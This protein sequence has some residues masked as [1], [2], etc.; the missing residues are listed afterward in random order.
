MKWS[1]ALT[2][3]SQC[4]LGALILD[5][6][7]QVR[8]INARGDELLHGDG[9]L[10]GAPLPAC[11][12]P[13]LQPVEERVYG[14][15][16]FGEY[17]AHCPTPTLEDLPEGYRFLVFQKADYEACHDMLLSALNQIKE[18]VIICD[19]DSRI[20]FLNDAAV[21]MDGLTN[22]GVVGE[23]LPNVYKSQDDKGLLVPWVIEHKQPLRDVRQ[24][25]TTCRGRA[26]DIMASCYPIVQNGQVLGGCSVMEDWSTVDELHKKIIDL[27]EKLLHVTKEG[28]KKAHKNVLKAKYHFEDIIFAS[29]A[30]AA[31][32]QRCRH[33]AKS[34]SSILIYGETGTGKELVAQSIHNASS[35]ADG[36][37][38][39]INC[40]AIPEN[41]LEGILFGMEK[42]AYTGA[43]QRPGLFEQA[44]GGTLLLDEINSMNINLQ[45]K[46]LRVLQEGTV[47]RVGGMTEHPVDVRVLSNMNITPQQ[48]LE[49]HKLRRDLFY[50]LGVVDL[51]VPPLRE[52][53]E[54]VPLLAKHF[55]MLYNQKLNKNVRNVD[56]QVLELFQSYNWPG[57][58]REL[59]HAIEFA[60]N[61]LPDDR[62][63]ITLDYIPENIV[64]VQQEEKDAFY[65]VQP[66]L[67]APYDKP[68][69]DKYAKKRTLREVERAAV[70]QALRHHQGNI[71]A[72]ARQLGMSRQNL[73]YRIKRDGIDLNE[74][75]S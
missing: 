50:R 29:D 36:P 38:L 57:N 14:N 70:C 26:V 67:I 2:A 61:V 64:Q 21:R 47:R 3:L 18:S 49:E 24:H 13:L 15:P 10:E 1:E 75:L 68:K 28:G 60:M 34:S 27:Q 7:G 43:E 39:A 12:V 8:K 4:G 19:Q 52:R 17:I 63:M 54:D 55:I 53:M 56:A 23:K 20:Y 72:A 35:R 44:D 74:F 66:G 32:M 31:L 73:Q 48:A 51:R 65:P 33:V 42:G 16:A 9:K 30:M 22:Y 11:A 46:L 58:V 25:Y 45:P 62:N 69:R 71:S 41:L 59:Q 6:D 5:L 40:A 37:F